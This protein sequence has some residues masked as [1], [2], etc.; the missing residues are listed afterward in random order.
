MSAAVHAEADGRWRRFGFILGTFVAVVPL[1][2][3]TAVVGVA[4]ALFGYDLGWVV[5]AFG[6]F[7]L[8]TL[9]LALVS[10]ALFGALA[11][12][13]GYARLWVALVP[14]LLM[15]VPVNMALG[16][17]WFRVNPVDIGGVL[18]LFMLPL[19]LAWALSRRWHR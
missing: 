5:M 2:V 10:G 6:F 13:R 7:W 19:L 1:V 3:A 8:F 14:A 18:A 11:V 15:P 4:R 17:P 16:W 12:F 9:P